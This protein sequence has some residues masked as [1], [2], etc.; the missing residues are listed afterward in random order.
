MPKGV[1]AMELLNLDLKRATPTLILYQCSKFENA[2][3]FVAEWE[4]SSKKTIPKT[5]KICASDILF[6]EF[7]LSTALF[8]FSYSGFLVFSAPRLK[9]PYT[10]I[11]YNPSHKIKITLHSHYQG[12]I[13][14][15]FFHPISREY[16]LL[17]LAS[18]EEFL[19][20]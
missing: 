6:A 11:I 14:G 2:L 13:C 18:W 17:W 8:T 16:R 19:F 5:E 4:D 3:I 7:K 9:P 12:E 1:Q 10:K 15:V 20:F